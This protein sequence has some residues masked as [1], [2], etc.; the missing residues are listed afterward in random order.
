MSKNMLSDFIYRYIENNQK[1]LIINSSTDTFPEKVSEIFNETFC[2]Q[3]KEDENKNQIK[4]PSVKFLNFKNF[5]N[6]FS[7]ESF[8]LIIINDWNKFQAEN[9]IFLNILNEVQ[10]ILKKHACILFVID[11]QNPNIKSL[12][13]LKNIESI[14]KD[15]NFQIS[16]DWILPS[17]SNPL[18]SG[19]LSNLQSLTW[20]LQNIENFIPSFKK[21]S[22]KKNLFFKSI[23]IINRKI[24]PFFIKFFTPSFIVCCSQDT[25]KSYESHLLKET[26]LK[27][28]IFVNRPFKIMYIL[29]DTNGNPKHTVSLQKKILPITGDGNLF[30][31]LDRYAQKRDWVEGRIINPLNPDEILYAISWIIDFQKSNQ[32]NIFKNNEVNAEINPIREMLSKTLDLKKYPILEWLSEYENFFK[33]NSIYKTSI[34]GDLSHKNMIL[35]PNM[36]NVEVIDWDFFKKTGN[37]MND[38]GNFLFRLL[39]KSKTETK[40]IAFK[41]KIEGNDQTFNDLRK[42][43]EYLFSNYFNLNFDILLA[44]KYHLLKSAYSKILNDEDLSVEL[45]YISTLSNICNENISHE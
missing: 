28:S 31:K 36:K 13:N 21:K 39:T 15:L 11:K 3:I 38:I 23:K 5:K 29:F 8:D 27:S 19:N 37:P 25:M 24:L 18:Y 14:F 1:C 33:N 41:S 35:K 6:H 26:R 4:F 43:I 9:S 32:Q 7:P 34:H 16:K 30:Q 40:I 45:E 2:L 22:F 10:K 42:E 20:F 17:I 44:I 12:N